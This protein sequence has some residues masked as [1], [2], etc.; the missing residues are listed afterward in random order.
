MTYTFSDQPNSYFRGI[1][2]RVG[3]TDD[4]RVI[5]INEKEGFW[6]LNVKSEWIFGQRTAAVRTAGENLTDDMMMRLEEQA[7]QFFYQEA[8]D[9]AVNHGFDGGTGQIFYEG[10]QGGW[11]CLEGTRAFEATHPRE[12]IDDEERQYIDKWLAFCFEADKLREVAEAHFDELIL[13]AN[14]ELQI[15]LSE[16]ADW[17]GAEVGTL[18]GAVFEVAKL[19]VINGKPALHTGH[20]GFAFAKEATLVRKANGQIP[21]RLTADPIMEQV[22]QIIEARGNLSRERIDHWLD[23]DDDNDPICLYE[24]H[25]APAVNAI[26]DLILEG[27]D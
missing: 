24:Q 25:V 27:S 23:A 16:Y 4:G 12:P 11:L 3:R 21:A 17:V 2:L 15:Q 26:E 18:D 19:S 1:D 13:R 20:S 8:E 22:L 9:L 7:K 6:A 14:Q 5:V 10:R